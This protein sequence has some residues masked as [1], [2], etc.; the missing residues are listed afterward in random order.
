MADVTIGA[1]LNLDADDAKKSIKDFRKELQEAKGDALA[2]A[3]KFGATSAEAANAAKR[4]AEL[5]DHMQDTKQ[6]V[7][8]FNPDTKF[9]AFGAALNTVVG[10]FS[11][12]Q[13]VMGLVGVESAD[14]QK[15]LLKVQS[16]LAISQGVAQLQE[17]I[18]SFQNLIVVIKTA[19][20]PVGLL[21]T[22]LLAIGGALVAW[23]TRAKEVTT[24]QKALND[25]TNDYAR[26]AAGAIQKVEEVRAAFAL[27]KTGVISKKEALKTYNDTLGD[28]LGKTDSLVVAEK[29][30][31]DKAEVYIRVTAL[32]AQANALFG[33]SAEAAANATILQQKL[34]ESLASN[35]PELLAAKVRKDIE[36]LKSQA[37]EIEDLG[38][39]LLRQ[40]AVQAKAAGV[41]VAGTGGSGTGGGTKTPEEVKIDRAK[42]F[43]AIYD[44][45]QQEAALKRVAD[46]QQEVIDTDSLD[47]LATDLAKTQSGLRIQNAEAETAKM[48]SLAEEEYQARRASAEAI[49]MALGALADLVG[50]QTT[51]GKVLA[52]AQATI[53][54][55]LGATEVLRAKSILPE[56]AGTIVKVASVATIIA[57]GISAIRNIVKTQVPGGGGSAPS[58]SSVEAPIKPQLAV[59]QRT[60]L[61]QN[62]LNAIGNS[63][64]RAFVVESDVSNNQE[65]IRM[66]NRRARI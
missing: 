38:A 50:K 30:L 9:R 8:A 3:E 54:T 47:T 43:N 1:K 32:K 61:D 26:A 4:V 58:F 16:A 42:N 33:K 62:T 48:I 25:T 20:G 2:L 24:A 7:D 29:N 57:S 60:S 21:L 41:S 23:F 45:I 65:R 28:S 34:E 13:G 22:A 44:A 55:F 18:K 11:A 51:A 59:A 40:A 52:I 36:S 39:D 19:L 46:K 37:K 6:L 12:L 64:I 27:A 5:Q 15:Q 17:G 10:G 56:P 63:A 66:L 31:T 14:L 35:L 53:N 49:G